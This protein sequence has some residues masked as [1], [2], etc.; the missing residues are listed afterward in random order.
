MPRLLGVTNPRIALILHDPPS[1][2]AATDGTQVIGQ[3]PATLKDVIAMP[4]DEAAKKKLL[5]E[6]A[7]HFKMALVSLDSIAKQIATAIGI[8]LKAQSGLEILL[9]PHLVL[10]RVSRRCIRVTVTV[11][12]RR[13]LRFLPLAVSTSRVAGTARPET[14]HPCLSMNARLR[15]EAGGKGREPGRLSSAILYVNVLTKL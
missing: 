12:S 1:S 14:A 10:T 5:L 8:R 4:S 13:S 3:V 7:E 9:P 11:S 2:G 6:L 15:G